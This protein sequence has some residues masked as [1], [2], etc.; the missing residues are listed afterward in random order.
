MQARP[1]AGRAH[2]LCASGA[3]AA[4]MKNRSATDRNRYG[5]KA[6]TRSIDEAIVE[7]RSGSCLRHM[8]QLAEQ[9]SELPLE[10]HDLLPALHRCVHVRI[11]ARARAFGRVCVRASAP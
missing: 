8:Q 11:W 1:C 2:A 10:H 4:L 6:L 7:R 5:T 3:Q 9:A